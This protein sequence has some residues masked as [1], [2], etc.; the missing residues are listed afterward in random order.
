ML[1]LLFSLGKEQ[2]DAR[3]AETQAQAMEVVRLFAMQH[4]D[5]LL[6]AKTL[7]ETLASHTDILG[8][9]LES[10]QIQLQRIAAANPQYAAFFLVG[11][12][13]R[14]LA[15]SLQVEKGQDMSDRAH[16]QCA[17]HSKR[18]CVGEP[19]RGPITN[20]VVLPMGVP[21]FNGQ[22]D[23]EAVL[24]VSFKMSEYA[25]FFA[26]LGHHPQMRFQL[27][28]IQG[29]RLLRSPEYEALPIGRQLPCWENIVASASDSGVFTVKNSWEKTPAIHAF[30]K[31]WEQSSPQGGFGVL[32]GMPGMCWSQDFWQLFGRSMF[33]TV[34]AAMLVLGLNLLFS[35]RIVYRGLESL[36]EGVK[37]IAE[38]K[39][40]P[41]M[42]NIIG[43]S[44][45]RDLG[46]QFSAMAESLRRDREARDQAEKSLRAETGRL[47]ILLETASDGIHVLDAQGDLVLYSPSFAKMLG[48]GPGE[49][50]GMNVSVWDP[51][52]CLDQ[53]RLDVLALKDTSR[54]FATR[55]RRKD[56]VMLDVEI[57]VRGVKLE[58]RSLLYA[59][60][61]DITTRVLAEKNLKDE[62]ARLA[63][64]IE[65]AHVGTWELDVCD[66]MAVVNDTWASFI[67]KTLDEVGVIPLSALDSLVHPEDIGGVRGRLDRHLRGE[68]PYYE[69]ECR[70]RH[71]DGH[72][73]WLYGRGRVLTRDQDGRPL[74]M[75][76][77]HQDISG[78]KAAQQAIQESQERYRA[79]FDSREAIKLILDPRDGAIKE[80]NPAAVEFYGYSREV[81]ERMT[82]YDVNVLPR[83]QV[84]GE[85]DK[86]VR[87]EKLLFSFRHRLASN[88]IR[89]VDVH[90]SPFQ[91]QGELFLMSSIHDVTELRKLERIRQDVDRIV[92]HD[93][94]TPLAGV[95]NIPLMLLEEG[96]LTEEQR[97]MLQL[98][99]FSGRKML[100]QLNSAQAMHRIE[101]GTY[102]FRPEACDL[103]P[104]LTDNVAILTASSGRGQD[105]FQV[106]AEPGLPQGLTL[107]TDRILLDVI[108]MNLLRNAMEASQPGQPVRVRLREEQEHCVIAISN[109]MPVPAGIRDRFFEKYVTAGK[110]GGSGLGTY[111]AAIMTRAIGGTISM[112]TSEQSGTTVT[113]RLP[114]G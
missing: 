30:I 113:I 70:V 105:T 79:F 40:P 53:L 16:F 87:G 24:L 43:C 51:G 12:D 100:N 2:Y 46:G 75:F 19:F 84:A 111:S 58:D 91:I 10:F 59:S 90:V 60:A 88:D 41:D 39:Q 50:L 13:G 89:D 14:L 35:R 8:H 52:A 28:D 47:N 66:G 96:G 97:E 73:V 86:A 95:I 1:A 82:V 69:G 45:I 83:E 3:K 23:V 103:V 106:L 93:L 108:L 94:K 4:N 65:G 62:R 112:E 63:N 85:L 33:L 17:L 34:L 5:V 36:S 101:G 81:L 99:A 110:A 54:V 25:S 109:V 68:I 74:K 29:K 102:V 56:G 104:M 31:F 18:F 49:M 64:I 76:G 42:S 98:V 38:N 67:G 32:V 72:W 107:K 55:H 77:T 61:R 27:F 114:V 44:E 78:R 71:K 11:A 26:H 48:Y 21:V 9:R 15:S 57:S 6:H 92:Q 22:G 7:L 80:A 20:H 37:G